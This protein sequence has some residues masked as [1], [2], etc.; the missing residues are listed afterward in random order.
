MSFRNGDKAR[1]GRLRKQKIA[2][3][4]RSRELKK[5]LAI[6]TGPDT[7]RAS[8]SPQ[9]GL[10]YQNAREKGAIYYLTK[11]PYI[12]GRQFLGASCRAIAGEEPW[13]AVRALNAM[14]G[15]RK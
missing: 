8:Y 2:R 11:A 4:V 5:K 12:P 3:R 15:E 13:G 1:S 6:N 10:F 7:S 9:T 14:T